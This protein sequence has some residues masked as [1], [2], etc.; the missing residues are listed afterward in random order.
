MSGETGMKGQEA[1]RSVPSISISSE[2]DWGTSSSLLQV[3]LERPSWKIGRTVNI[4][5]PS[6]N[7]VWPLTV[8]GR[9]CFWVLATVTKNGD[10]QKGRREGP[11]ERAKLVFHWLL[12]FL[13]FTIATR[14]CKRF[15]WLS[16]VTNIIFLMNSHHRNPYYYKQTP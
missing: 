14:K 3:G 2:W 1:P 10:G 11:R 15:M 9:N 5:Y 16:L 8:L 12:F 7:L 6:P 4:T 13:Q